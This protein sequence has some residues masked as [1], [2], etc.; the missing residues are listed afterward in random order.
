MSLDQL[1]EAISLINR[2]Q[3]E[4]ARP[5]LIEFLKIKPQDEVAWR[6]LTRVL[7]TTDQK[8]GAIEHC[9]KFNPHSKWA[10]NALKELIEEQKTNSQRRSQPAVPKP[11][12]AKQELIPAGI[13]QARDDQTNPGIDWSSRKKPLIGDG[14]SGPRKTRPAS[15]PGGIARPRGLSR[16]KNLKSAAI[17]VGV[18]G[19][20]VVLVFYLLGRGDNPRVS[21]NTPAMATQ[22]TISAT[23]DSNSSDPA[24]PRPRPTPTTP[25]TS[26][27][28]PL[29]GP[30]A[31]PSLPP[32]SD[33]P[34]INTRNAAGITLLS[35]WFVD[36]AVSVSFSPDGSMLAVG[37]WDGTIWI[38]E[39]ATFLQSSWGR[40]QELYYYN[41]PFGVNTVAFSPD[42]KTLAF[43]ISAIKEPLRLLDITVLG[44]GGEP[45]MRSFEGHT[46]G[47]KSIVFSPD[48]T[49]VATSSFDNTVRLWELATGRELGKIEGLYIEKV[50]FSPDG[51]AFATAYFDHGYS[52]IIW[53]F[54]RLLIEGAYSL[55]E[56]VIVDGGPGVVFSL[57]GQ[58]FVT[59]EERISIWSA[60]GIASGGPPQKIQTLIG[61]PGL[62]QCL[63]LTPNGLILAS[64]ARDRTIKLWDTATGRELVT[65]GGHE[66]RL[67]SLA[68]SPDGSILASAADDGSV[69]IWGISTQ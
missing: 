3:L 33:H 15:L 63:A 40:G 47:V 69:R 14:P 60:P 26:T 58:Q 43:G 28:E 68:F 45:G 67:H 20:G 53:D 46:E 41:Q 64:G 8:I 55:E 56:A 37:S 17:G 35:Q 16:F 42:G 4:A 57:D 29:R 39:T 38:W 1:E 21:A 24:T 2:G 23:I 5:L 12:A 61:H 9:L 36:E 32:I 52:T 11:E 48:G 13:F 44:E 51:Q 50:T 30:L 65:L 27:A 19:L 10:Q 31:V 49:I 18:L 62:V 66:D 54:P 25:P 7:P 59:A 22:S 6:Y 34:I